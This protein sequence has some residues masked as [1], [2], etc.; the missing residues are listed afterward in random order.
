MHAAA[1]M[2]ACN[3]QRQSKYTN[4]NVSTTAVAYTPRLCSVFLRVAAT[5]RLASTRAPSP[6]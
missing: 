2:H 6:A 1:S 5:M 3:Q 4:M